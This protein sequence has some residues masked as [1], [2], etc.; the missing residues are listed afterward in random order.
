[1][2]PFDSPLTRFPVSVT[3]ASDSGAGATYPLALAPTLGDGIDLY[4]IG[5]A[6]VFC[7]VLGIVVM[8]A[9]R[10]YGSARLGRSAGP[11]ARKK[12]AI[13]ETTRLAPRAT[14]HLIEY[15]ERRVLVVLH[16]NGVSLLDAYA[17]P[18]SETT[19]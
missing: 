12:L 13:V 5:G 4:R 19:S 15:D 14:L 11:S 18:S 10:R 9:L 2:Q 8:L 3:S 1:M 7:V 17:R 6:L 16:P